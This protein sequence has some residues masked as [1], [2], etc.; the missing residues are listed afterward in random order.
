MVVRHLAKVE[1]AG[2]S[3]VYRSYFLNF[4]SKDVSILRGVIRDSA[5]ADIPQV[6]AALL[7]WSD[8][9]VRFYG[10]FRKMGEPFFD[11]VINEKSDG[12]MG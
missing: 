4:I 10:A 12:R 3:P 5:R 11:I 6:M 8:E 1:V 7:Q 2:S 9:K